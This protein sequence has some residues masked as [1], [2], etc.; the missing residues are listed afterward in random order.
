MSADINHYCR[1]IEALLFASPESMSARAIRKYLPDDADDALYDAVMAALGARYGAESGLELCQMDGHWAF[2]TR[3]DIAEHLEAL[4]ET[5]KPLSRAGLE[6]LAIIAYH[7]PVT[8]A[9][10]EEIRGVTISKGTLDILLEMGWIRPKG[11]KRSPGRPVTWGTSH[12][13]LD[14]FGLENITDLPG[15]DELKRSGLLRQGAV[16][17]DF[18]RPADADGDEEDAD[19]EE[20][21]DDHD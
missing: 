18:L 12:E 4:R 20:D 21:G 11:R 14:H 7:Q 2:R 15:L 17:S 6:T 9:E 3:P 19:G 5:E 1:I 8:R 10:I 13:F 16:I